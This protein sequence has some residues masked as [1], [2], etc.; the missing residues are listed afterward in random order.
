MGFTPQC[1]RINANGEEQ[2]AGLSRSGVLDPKLQ[3]R[4]RYRSLRGLAVHRVEQ[5]LTCGQ[6]L[7]ASRNHVLR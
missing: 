3:V 1:G 6:Y 5:L 7:S 2:Q 4:R